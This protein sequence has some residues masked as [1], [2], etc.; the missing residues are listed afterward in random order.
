MNIRLIPDFPWVVGRNVLAH[1]RYSS[2]DEE[3]HNC[4]LAINVESNILVHNILMS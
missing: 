1:Y 2:F 3:V 4:S